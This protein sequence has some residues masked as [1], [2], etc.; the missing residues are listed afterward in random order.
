MQSSDDL[1]TFFLD[2][3][4]ITTDPSGKVGIR[5]VDGMMVLTFDLVN[6]VIKPNVQPQDYP[7]FYQTDV[8]NVTYNLVTNY[9]P[10]PSTS[11]SD[12]QDDGSTSYTRQLYLNT[13][14]SFNSILFRTVD[15]ATNDPTINVGASL[16]YLDFKHL[17]ESKNFTYTV[18][19]DYPENQNLRSLE[20]FYSDLFVALDSK[21]TRM[22]LDPVTL[23]VLKSVTIIIDG[24]T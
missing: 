14:S 5:S 6:L 20:I 11:S 2:Y 13:L 18:F 15:I 23:A 22:S 4:F 12:V 24:V 9:D 21:V 10:T 8:S 19:Q 16:Q 1:G 7:S 17:E 3:R